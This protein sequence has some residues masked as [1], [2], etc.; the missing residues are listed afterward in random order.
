MKRIVGTPEELIQN[1]ITAY[2]MIDAED[3]STFVHYLRETKST[4]HFEMTKPVEF[5][6]GY[7][8]TTPNLFTALSFGALLAKSIVG[9]IV[10]MDGWTYTPEIC[11][12]LFEMTEQERE[13]WME[14]NPSPGQHPDRVRVTNVL[15]VL[16][17]GRHYM[18]VKTEGQETMI[19][20]GE[21][22]EGQQVDALHKAMGG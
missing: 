15:M 21:Q 16:K 14:E 2:E 5:P 3:R 4:E 12:E 1:V 9:A 20:S 17:D 11:K 19:G 6:C 8:P 22:V 10:A 18:G 13:Q 7:K